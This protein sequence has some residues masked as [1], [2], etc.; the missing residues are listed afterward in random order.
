MLLV[1]QQALCGSFDEPVVRV[2]TT[3]GVQDR[4]VSLGNSD[5]FWTVVREG[6]TEGEQVVVEAAQTSTDQFG[7]FRQFRPGGAGNFTIIGGRR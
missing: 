2:M 7:A 4:A 1:P 6:L 3:N 5:D